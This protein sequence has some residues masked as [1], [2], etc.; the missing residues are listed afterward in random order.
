[1]IKKIFIIVFLSASLIFASGNGNTGLSFLK[2]GFGA[3]NLAMSDLGVS[4]ATGVSGSFYNPALISNYDHS[5]L[6]FSHT[7]WIQDLRSELLGAGFKVFNLPFAVSLN[8]TKLSGVEIRTKPTL[9]PDATFDINYF[10]GSLTTGFKVYK[11]LSFGVT[12]KY[13]YENILSDEANG[14]GFDFGVY[15][16]DIMRNLN[17]AASL[18]NIG[19]MNAL[20]NAST[21]LPVDLRIGA[22]YNFNLESI[23]SKVIV[24]TGVQKYT[25]SDDTHLHFG[26]EIFYRNILSLRLGYASGYETKGLTFGAGVFWKSI[27]FDYAFVP[28]SLNLGNSHVISLK[29]NF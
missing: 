4:T 2:I 5:Q 15:Y 10:Y 17:I 21:K 22:D 3:R 11:S 7:E 27:N 25:S 19:S 8:T 6:F 13:I 18:K 28:F 1:M 24:L 29:Y 20:R 9:E 26:A 12:V 23:D 14:L 16:K